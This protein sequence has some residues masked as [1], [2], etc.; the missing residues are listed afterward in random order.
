MWDIIY[1]LNNLLSKE[2]RREAVGLIW[3]ILIMASFEVIGIASIIPFM[4]V[5]TNPGIIHSNDKL[6]WLY[7]VLHFTDNNRFLLFLGL[8][9]FGFLIFSIVFTAFT[10]QLLLKFTQMRGHSIAKRLFTKYIYE[11]Y[12]FFLNRNSADLSGS[13]LSEVGQMINCVLVP[14]MQLVAKSVVAIFIIGLLIIVN[15]M[16]ALFVGGFI[17]MIYLIFYFI[18]RGK[19]KKIGNER[20]RLSLAKYKIAAEGLDG[21]KEIKLIQAEKVIIERFSDVSERCA[22]YQAMDNIIT[23]LSKSVIEA[24][25]FGG[26]LLIVL[27]ML[28]VR[29]N[30]GLIVPLI[31][32]YVFAGYRLIPALHLIFSGVTTIRFYKPSLNFVF[33]D[34]K[35]FCF[36]TEQNLS[37]SKEGAIMSFI[38][39]LRMESI[40]FTYSKSSEPLIRDLDIFIKAQTKVAFV[41]STGAGKTT[42]IDII[43]GLLLPQ[44]GSILVDGVKINSS[45]LRAWQKNIGYVPQ[46]IFLSDDTVVRNIAFGVNYD[47]I[48][49]QAVERAAKIANIHDFIF[50]E[51]PNGYNTLIG[52]RGIRLS[53][54]QRQRIC[55]ARA[56]YR[57]PSVLIFDEATNSLDGV[58]E[59][60]VIQAIN[61]L[62]SRKTI[63]MIAHRLSTVRDSDMIY[64]IEKGKLIGKGA[65]QD[66]VNSCEIFN[67]L[68]K[69]GS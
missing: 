10:N 3:A 43:L 12:E 65:Y 14:G 13:I 31:S 33:N 45:N 60:A 39:E 42:I 26:A 1:K 40:T 67:A 62:P 58:T 25:A 30:L 6:S 18:V 20:L 69:A 44:G 46:N 68:T 38:N 41:G 28:S 53:G 49:I 2:E 8:V 15:P 9:I 36:A 27:Y 24:I 37:G 16:L 51:L 22:R 47:D 50:H 11:P 23:S 21:I 4:Q 52:E 34:L 55:I 66:L 19:V 57:D 29:V 48:D 35:G 32:V 63:I 61:N 59:E 64:V 54:G 5:I 7:N 17:C 56:L